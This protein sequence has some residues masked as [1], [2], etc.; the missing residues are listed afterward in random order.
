[1]FGMYRRGLPW[2]GASF[3]VGLVLCAGLVG[4]LFSGPKPPKG[5]TEALLARL[6]DTVRAGDIVVRCGT[7]LVSAIIR[8]KVGDSI[9]ASHCGVVVGARGAFRVVHSL[10]A[11]VSDFDGLQSCSLREFVEESELSS[12]RVVR[13]KQGNGEAIAARALGYLARK[14]PFNEAIDLSD[15]TRLF[16]SQLPLRIIETQ[17]G[18]D[19]VPVEVRKG[20]KIPKFSLFLDSVYFQRV[21]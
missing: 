7:G 18:V 21:Y 10:S 11:S 9:S 15:T 1:M 6:E 16:C 17:Y 8:A 2:G 19:L 4:C 12:L 20:Q 14:V 5:A 3:F 13:F